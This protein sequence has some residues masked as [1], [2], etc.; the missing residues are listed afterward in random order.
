MQDKEA[1]GTEIGA[2]VGAS[3]SSKA[4]DLNN[5]IKKIN[6]IEADFRNN[7]IKNPRKNGYRSVAMRILNILFGIDPNATVNGFNKNNIDDAT[8][9]HD[10][11][12]SDAAKNPGA[13]NDTN[14][15]VPLSEQEHRALHKKGVKPKKTES[16]H[17]ASK[18]VINKKRFSI[19]LE[20]LFDLLI[21]AFIVGFFSEFIY[22]FIHRTVFER[23]RIDGVF[24]RKH[25][26]NSLDSALIIFLFAIPICLPALIM[27]LCDVEDSTVNI[28]QYVF[29]FVFFVAGVIISAVILAKKGH[30]EKEVAK[31]VG[32]NI[33][34][35][36][37]MICACYP[38]ELIELSIKNKVLE[39]FVSCIYLIIVIVLVRFL[40]D[41]VANA[42]SKRK[43][44]AIA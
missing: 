28:V 8:I 34:K 26:V 14:N 39:T 7:K 35:G 6:K 5:S 36:L 17:R 1:V 4:T 16:V 30:S 3:A 37:V 15:L 13:M 31:S 42:V 18:R 25:I 23:E 9:H 20:T 11:P 38:C 44:E 27:T 29:G 10:T 33:L 43:G 24:V 21:D 19:C 32:A 40:F 12:V 41:L 22:G 2:K